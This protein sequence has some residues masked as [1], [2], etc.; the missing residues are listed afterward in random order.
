MPQKPE[1]RGG[2][3]KIGKAGARKSAPSV[4]KTQSAR[5]IEAARAAGVDETGKDFERALRRIIPPR[6]R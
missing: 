3:R 2:P 6:K 1:A 5:F 4:E